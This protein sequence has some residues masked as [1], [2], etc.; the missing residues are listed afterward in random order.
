MKKIK[1]EP[2]IVVRIGGKTLS[3]RG[4]VY[5]LAHLSEE[6]VVELTRQY[7]GVNLYEVEYPRIRERENGGWCDVLTA[8]GETANESA[9]RRE[10]AEA[11]LS[12]LE[13]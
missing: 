8:P 11:L 1:V 10:D 13:D 9:L 4:G 5:E 12:E 7:E 3:T 6:E 2:G